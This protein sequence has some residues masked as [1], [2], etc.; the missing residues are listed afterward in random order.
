[1]D[2]VEG[3]DVDDETHLT[4]VDALLRALPVE[5]ATP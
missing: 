4:A 1:M 3:I 2:V 5:E